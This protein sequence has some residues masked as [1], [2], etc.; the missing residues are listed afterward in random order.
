MKVLFYIFIIALISGIY[1]YRLQT[2]KNLLKGYYPK[3]DG[4]ETVQSIQSKFDSLVLVRLSDDLRKAGLTGFP[5]NMAMLIFK[6]ERKL[7]LYSRLQGSN[8]FIK[9]YPFT[10]F[11]GKPGPKLKEG[12]RQIPEGVYQIEYLNPN[13]SYHLS[14]KINYP[15]AFDRQMAKNDNRTNPGGD[16]FIHGKNKTIGCVPVG[17][18]GIEELFILMSHVLPSRIEVIISPWDFRVRQDIP[19]LEKVDWETQLYDQIK[20]AL[21]AY[22]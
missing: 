4:S 12:D 17:D 3:P 16:I 21:S 7:E 6:E 5:K 10:A 11:S 9:S 2:P 15:N 13:S 18:R 14:A 22:Q 8:I 20:A 1:W 19:V